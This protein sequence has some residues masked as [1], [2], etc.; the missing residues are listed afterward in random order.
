MQK[1]ANL[2]VDY[3]Q[4]GLLYDWSDTKIQP[5]I[6]GTVGVISMIPDAEGVETETQFAVTP[7]IGMRVM[8]SEKIAV[9]FQGRFVWSL[10]PEGPLFTDY[11]VHEKETFLTQVQLGVGVAYRF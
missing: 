1:I 7:I 2:N 3:Y 9:R 8:L 10:T 11:Y 4:I 6:G 5:F